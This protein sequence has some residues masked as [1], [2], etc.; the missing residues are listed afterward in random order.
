MIA[1]GRGNEAPPHPRL[2]IM[3]AHQAPDLLVV[4]DKALLTQRRADAAIAVELELV[5]D[6]EHRLDDRGVVGRLLRTVVVGR[7]RDPHQP[8]SF[9]DG[10]AAGPVM[11]DV[12]PLLGRGAFLRAP[13]RNSSSRAC[14]PTSRSSAAIRASY[15]WI[16]SAACASSSK[17]PSSYLRTQMRIRLRE[18]SWRFARPCSV[19]P[20]EILLRD[21]PLELDAVSAMLCHGFSLRK[22]GKPGQFLKP[23]CP[24]PGAHPFRDKDMRKIKNSKARRL[25]SF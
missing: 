8:A 20:R 19:S 1:V 24:P 16:R 17:A 21:L 9:G 2:Q 23:I 18:T 4:H 11:T 12:V 7:A 25:N 6:R 14:L 5:A 13:F 3:L 22:P 10:D 15:S